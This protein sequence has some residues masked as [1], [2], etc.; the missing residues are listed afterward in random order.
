[1][2]VS[3]LELR[4]PVLE[5][6]GTLGGLVQ[7]PAPKVVP[8]GYQLSRDYVAAGYPRP[9]GATPVRVLA[10]ARLRAV[11][12]RAN[13]HARPAARVRRR[14]TRRSRRPAT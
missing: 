7:S 4:L 1:M 13:R 10:R 12:R 5:Q 3:N 6:P 2:T 9:K 8:A 11:H 14:A